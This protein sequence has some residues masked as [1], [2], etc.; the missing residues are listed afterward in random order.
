MKE[1][2]KGKWSGLMKKTGVSS[3]ALSAALL[4]PGCAETGKSTIPNSAG[5]ETSVS[6]ISREDALRFLEE[7]MKS[8][9]NTAETLNK[10]SDVY[11]PKPTSTVGT[12][13]M[14]RTYNAHRNDKFDLSSIDGLIFTQTR[15]I[16]NQSIIDSIN[17]AINN[18]NSENYS[19]AAFFIGDALDRMPTTSNSDVQKTVDTMISEPLKRM[20]MV[21]HEMTLLSKSGKLFKGGYSR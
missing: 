3:L 9:L 7:S 15:F 11:L 1:D 17:S 18:I 6:N 5:V 21:L 12:L 8:I 20:Y 2:S 4:A 10:R 13:P 16:P 14:F 19:E